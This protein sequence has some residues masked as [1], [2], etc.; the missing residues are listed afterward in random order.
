MRRR[1]LL[2]SALALAPPA[3]ALAPPASALAPPARAAAIEV[4]G[5]ADVYAEPGLALAWAVLR[6][7][8]AQDPA[9]AL[10]VLTIELDSTR[11]AQ[12]AALRRD[13]FGSGQVE[14]QPR[15]GTRASQV[16]QARRGQL[17]EHPRTELRF[18]AAGAAEPQRIVWFV[19]VPDTT[20]EYLSP[21]A[22]AA[23]VAERLQRMR[24]LLR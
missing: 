11:H 23:G 6:G 5:A 17:A 15:A 2:G 9:D 12:F 20:P 14:W 19:G 8:A 16:L 22:L 18:W 24:S 7:G 13:P 3:P 1:A 21:Q 10:V 4:H